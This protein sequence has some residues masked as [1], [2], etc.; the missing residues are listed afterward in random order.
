MAI[1]A[2]R[3]IAEVRS[4][5]PE[6]HTLLARLVEH[7]EA[8]SQVWQ[9]NGD[10]THLLL[11]SWRSGD[12]DTC[13]RILGVMERGL[14]DTSESEYAPV[15]NS[16]GIGV[17]ETIHRDLAPDDFAAF[18]ETWPPALRAQGLLQTTS[19][20]DECCDEGPDMFRI[21][22]GPRVRWALRH[23]ISSRL[24]TRIRFAG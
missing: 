9:L 6:A 22:L 17:V 18:V 14:I 4:N 23:P 2:E 8:L 3:Y 21:P 12:R 16:V 20:D 7:H 1:S 11:W 13:A 15:W 10:L 19:W 5:L 24:G